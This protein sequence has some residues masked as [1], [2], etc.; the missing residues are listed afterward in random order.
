MPRSVQGDVL[1]AVPR[2]ERTREKQM[3]RSRVFVLFASFTALAMAAAACGDDDGIDTS[4]AVSTTAAD[5]SGPAT[6]TP[7]KIGYHSLEGGAISLPEVRIGWEEGIKYV[8]D[9][10]GINGHPIE[11]IIC[12]VDGSPESSIDCAN[13]LIEAG[14]VAAVQGVDIGAD[15][16][17]PVLKEADMAEI[18]FVA[19]GPQ[20]Q[21]D[22]GHSFFFGSPLPS[23]NIAALLAM[24][25]AGA[26]T[27]RY[28]IADTPT[29]H[30]I[31]DE[32]IEPISEQL[33]MD[34][35]SIYYNPA[36]PDWTA[37]VSTALADNPDGIGAFGAPEPD[38]IGMMSAITQIGFDGPVF[39][40]ACTAFIQVLGA[41]KVAG[42]MTFSEVYLP[43][44]VD[45]APSDKKGNVQTYI[46]RMT[47]AG[48]EDLVNGFA[49]LGFET[50][51]D[52]ADAFSQIENGSG[53]S[54]KAVLEGMPKVT[55]QRFM[56]TDYNCDGSAWPGETACSL[57]VLV[58][59]VVGD[60]G[61]E[62]VSDGFLDLSKYRPEK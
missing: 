48:H 60:G 6:G 36:G 55:G 29:S 42:T 18:G 22:V 61:S 59:R 32:L 46:D 47:E 13:T 15:A 8:N 7:I 14:A 52:V 23:Y 5:A 25:D 21:T 26:K 44:L 53:L 9:H 30:A 31:N 17:L 28:F 37:L 39:A 20:Q 58:L 35:T 4:T 3:R 19:F 12:K 41:D 38:C 54:A 43:G 51:V 10:G 57:G 24:R 50:A 40:G 1:G 56:G 34:A 49:Q 2:A 16:M 33:G 11:S 62:L 45:A 27:V